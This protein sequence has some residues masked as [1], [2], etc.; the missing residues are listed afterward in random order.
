M[1]YGEGRIT[2]KEAKVGAF[3]VAA[4][5]VLGGIGES[6]R[7]HVEKAARNKFLQAAPTEQL[8]SFNLGAVQAKCEDRAT[9]KEFFAKPNTPEQAKKLADTC[10]LVF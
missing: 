6:Y 5:V 9:G 2:K 10:K 7:T 4:A 3:I 8:E 1:S